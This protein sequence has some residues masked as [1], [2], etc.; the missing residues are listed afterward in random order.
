MSSIKGT[1]YMGECTKRHDKIIN[2]E[3]NNDT[4]LTE[5]KE[6]FSAFGQFEML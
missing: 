2:W 5:Q 4:E 1:E 3:K 6:L